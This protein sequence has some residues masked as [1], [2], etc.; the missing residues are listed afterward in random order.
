VYRRILVAIDGSR[1]AAR[2]LSE[3][4]RLASEQ[5]ASLRIVHV[6]DEG[7]TLPPDV[8]SANL[9]EFDQKLYEGGKSLL[10]A[11]ESQARE[12]GVR[13]VEGILVEELGQRPGRFI[14]EQATDWSAELIVCGT[15]GRRGLMRLALGSDAEYVV[16]HSSVPVLLLRGGD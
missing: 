13:Q 2:A 15:H 11:S 9:A 16:R 1:P 6:I 8:L 3:A 7:L 4:I 5:Q 14:V 10:R 12:A